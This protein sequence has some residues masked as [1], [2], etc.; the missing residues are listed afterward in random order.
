MTTTDP[1]PALRISGPADL[2]Q[3]IPYLLGFHPARSLVLVGLADARLVVTARMDVDDLADEATL[4]H[5]MASMLRGGARTLVVAVFDDDPPASGTGPA[6]QG[7][8]ADLR[9]RCAE[10]GVAV[11]VAADV[12]DVL[13][14]ARGRWWSL[15]C[16]D[17]GCCPPEGHELPEAPPVV[18]AATYAGLVAL[19]DRDSLGALLDPVADTDREAMVPHLAAAEREAG[20]A[21]TPVLRRRWELRQRRALLTAAAAADSRTVDLDVAVVAG[22][23]V[24]LRSIPVRDAMWAAA[25]GGRI[26][27]RPLWREL[28]RRLPSPY[29]AAPLFLF[30]WGSWR[31]GHG[32]LANI[33]CDRSLASDPAYSAAD[34]LL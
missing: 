6:W 2:L 27:G 4:R 29:D 14:V 33:A 1:T 5:T 31:H 30:G 7:L 16:A 28:A 18:A 22:F 9:S 11:G 32:A 13:L 17:P 15:R 21:R 19:P 3:A 24:A 26:D 10:A 25:D 8:P 20:E 23:G 12:A 34:L